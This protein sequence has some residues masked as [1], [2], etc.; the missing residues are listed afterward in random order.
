MERTKSHAGIK[1]YYSEL[2]IYTVQMDPKR[3][4]SKR[5][6]AGV[7]KKFATGP[8]ITCQDTQQRRSDW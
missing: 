2:L 6:G 3:V 8:Q 7:L 1:I 4:K 5:S